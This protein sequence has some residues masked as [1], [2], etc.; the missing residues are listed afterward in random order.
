MSFHS[1]TLFLYQ[2]KQYQLFLFYAACLA[3]EQQI[4]IL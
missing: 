1:D 4:P 2:T 3:E